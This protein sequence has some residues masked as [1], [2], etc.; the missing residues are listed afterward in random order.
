[1]RSRATPS[2][3]PATVGRKS[4]VAMES[5]PLWTKI[6]TDCYADLI[7]GQSTTFE[8]GIREVFETL[9]DHEATI[10]AHE[11]RFL[12]GVLDDWEGDG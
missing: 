10:R 3:A 8:A 11:D 7:G 2:R 12:P 9:R 6:E 5:D 4:V 1:M